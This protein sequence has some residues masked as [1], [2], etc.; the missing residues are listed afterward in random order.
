M[1]ANFV[2]IDATGKK[3]EI[4]VKAFNG[5]GRRPYNRQ[6][7]DII[8]NINNLLGNRIHFE[9]LSLRLLALR[10][11]RSKALNLKNII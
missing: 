8:G 6:T 3:V 1:A 4:D 11:L 5:N 2:G 9:N 7:Q 10:N